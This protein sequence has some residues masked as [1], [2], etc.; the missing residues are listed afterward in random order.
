MVGVG[1][2][3]L[4]GG[5]GL[6]GYAKEQQAAFGHARQ[7]WEEGF[8]VVASRTVYVTGVVSMAL[9]AGLIGF[10]AIGMRKETE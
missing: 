1:A 9:G 6:T 8:H 10:G 7:I 3:L 2:V 5:W 4:A